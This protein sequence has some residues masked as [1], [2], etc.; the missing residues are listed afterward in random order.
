M[1]LIGARIKQMSSWFKCCYY[2]PTRILW[3]LSYISSKM[4][5]KCCRKHNMRGFF[6]ILTH[7][8]WTHEKHVF[9]WKNSLH[10]Q[11]P[12]QS[13]GPCPETDTFLRWNLECWRLIDPICSQSTLQ[14]KKQNENKKTKKK[15]R[16]ASAWISAIFCVYVTRTGDVVMRKRSG[17]R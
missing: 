12:S 13:C 15:Q 10:W 14:R 4:L 9:H 17:K 16:T 1:S 2:S 7:K 11:T 8:F 5:S 3:S 6:G